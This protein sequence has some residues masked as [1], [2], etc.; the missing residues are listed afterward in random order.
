MF[1]TGSFLIE[2]PVAM[3]FTGS[4]FCF[5]YW[6]FALFLKEMEAL[7]CEFDLITVDF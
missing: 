7:R 5:Q 3:S 2:V 1:I 4:G 6:L